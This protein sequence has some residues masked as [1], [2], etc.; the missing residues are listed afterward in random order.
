MGHNQQIAVIFSLIYNI[1]Q[2][3]IHIFQF[4]K[5]GVKGFRNFSNLNKSAVS[6]YGRQLFIQA[7]KSTDHSGPHFNYQS[8]LQQLATKLIFPILSPIIGIGL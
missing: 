6:I 4:T 5:G 7:L 2:P 8:N 1:E 3:S